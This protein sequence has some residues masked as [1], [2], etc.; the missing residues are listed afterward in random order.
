MGNLELQFPITLITATSFPALDH[1]CRDL[2]ITTTA[3]KLA[4][5]NYDIIRINPRLLTLGT[6]LA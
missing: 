4:S 3:N 6:S 2:L 5:Q 1:R